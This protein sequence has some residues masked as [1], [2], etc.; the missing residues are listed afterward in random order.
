MAATFAD[1]QSRQDQISI[2]TIWLAVAFSIL[3]HT[4]LLWSWPNLLPTE[5]LSPNDDDQIGNKRGSL[6]VR[7]AAPPVPPPPS[8][9][10]SPPAP[11]LA[12]KPAPQAAPSIAAAPPVMT[13]TTPS[14]APALTARSAPPK[15]AAPP[16]GGDF[17]SFVA[18]RQRQRA[19]E[20]RP[21]PQQPPDETE[22][23]R[24]NREVARSLG[25]NRGDSM[26]ANRNQGGGIFQIISIN[27]R[28]AMVAFYGW[29]KTIERKV[30]QTI[31]VNRGDQPG[32]EIAVVR[33][34]IELIRTQA[35]GSFTW[36]SIRLKRDV[37]LS[38]RMADQK[39]LED[40]LMQEFFAMRVQR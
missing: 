17:A 8:H 31:E 16:A 38:S 10:P 5:L 37:Q 7:L 24:H 23:D 29:N 4:L 6:A 2:P 20:E 19:E 39:E 28:T 25:L 11:H 1:V 22:Q 35:P 40:F 14:P 3:L 15:P 30:L 33:R 9:A 21:Q 36:E 32:I 12:Q 18:Q 27:D 34:M 26:G 13:R